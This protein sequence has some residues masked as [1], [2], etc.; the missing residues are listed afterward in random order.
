LKRDA[1]L[2]LA[3]GIPQIL[4]RLMMGVHESIEQHGPVREALVW[5]PVQ[6]KSAAAGPTLSDDTNRER[7]M[8]SDRVDLVQAVFLKL[9]RHMDIV[10]GD[11]CRD[12]D[13]TF[14]GIKVATIAEDLELDQRSV[15]RAIRDLRDVGII[16]S[17]KRAEQKGDRWIGHTSIR[18]LAINNLVALVGIGKAWL[19]AVQAAMR[20][21]ANIPLST[22]Q[23]AQQALRQSARQTREARTMGSVM[24]QAFGRASGP[25]GSLPIGPPLKAR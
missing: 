6:G 20:K 8:R 5:A 1:A 10:T 11:I 24:A 21:R 14:V 17:W 23:K 25:P 18:K 9:L 4:R 16:Q 12:Q 13:K 2:E 22:E 19:E 3:T 7:R 15:E